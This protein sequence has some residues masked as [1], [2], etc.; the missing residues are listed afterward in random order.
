MS[1]RDWLGDKLVS[2][3]LKVIGADAKIPLEAAA[4]EEP[5]DAPEMAPW[6]PVVLTDEARRMVEEGRRADPVFPVPGS[7]DAP[8]A[9]SI[10]DRVL[11]ERAKLE[12]GR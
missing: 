7:S 9:G 11:K 6:P 2:V 4:E 12:M 8:L 1:F 3:G 5:D 10:Q